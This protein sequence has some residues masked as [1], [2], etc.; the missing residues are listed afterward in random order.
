MENEIKLLNIDATSVCKALEAIGATKVFDGVRTITHFDTP[1]RQYKKEGTQI[2][3]TKEG[4]I[5]LT[6][7]SGVGTQNV[8]EVK[9]KTGDAMYSLLTMLHLE[10]I[11][12][13]DAHRISYELEDIDFDIDCF[14][15]IPPFLE[16][17]IASVANLEKLLEEVGMTEYERVVMGTPEV[18]ARYGKDYF[19]EYS[20]D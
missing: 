12:R 8:H 20:V 1:E 4:S 18:F 10:P 14:P 9:T 11:S 17:D 13:V 5:K 2:K 16:I 7:T 19:E 6:I 15:G 3:V